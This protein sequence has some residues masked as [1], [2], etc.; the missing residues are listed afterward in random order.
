VTQTAA[1]S[2]TPCMT[3]CSQVS[4]SQ[5]ISQCR[6][7]GRTPQPCGVRRGVLTANSAIVPVTLPTDRRSA[8]TAGQPT[9]LL[10]SSDA[11]LFQSA[12]KAYRHA[13]GPRGCRVAV[14]TSAVVPGTLSMEWRCRAVGQRTM[15]HR[16]TSAG[17]L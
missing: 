11:L 17:R 14:S 7:G 13:R 2:P 8:P 16:L 4:A 15:H 9:P 5:S 3:R 6:T 1:D 12:C 10:T